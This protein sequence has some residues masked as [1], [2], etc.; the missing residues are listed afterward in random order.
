MIPIYEGGSVL[1]YSYKREA[2]LQCIRQ[3]NTH[4]SADWIYNQLKE[5]IPDLSLGTVYRN[6]AQFKAKG[7]ILSLGV[8]GG[9]ERFDG[10]VD[11]HV[12]FCCDC[13]GAIV[14]LPTFDMPTE[15]CRKVAEALEAEVSQCSLTFTGLCRKCASEHKK[16]V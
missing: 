4:P 8:V 16:F 7:Q 1:K 13:C 9:I 15:L 5:R 3:T 11:P 6:L 12:H 10:R 14:D 2:I